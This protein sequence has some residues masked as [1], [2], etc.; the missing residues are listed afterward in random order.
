MSPFSETKKH[1]EQGRDTEIVKLES[2]LPFGK[3]RKDIWGADMLVR[4]G[5]MGMAIQCTDETSHGKHITKAL[6]NPLV[7]NWLRLGLAFAIISFGW[8]G[9][10]GQEKVRTMRETHLVFNADGSLQALEKGD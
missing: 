4:I 10:R 3:R 9:P 8:R 7:K 2:W 1:F 6:D 5:S